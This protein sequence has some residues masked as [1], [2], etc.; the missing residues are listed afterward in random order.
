MFEIADKTV[1]FCT[2]QKAYSKLVY[3]FQ[4]TAHYKEWHKDHISCY[5]KRG[6]DF[7]INSILYAK[8]FLDKIPFILGFKIIKND[9]NK[10]ILFKMLFPFS[11]ICRGGY[12]TF[13]SNDITTE[14]AAQL[15]F[16]GGNIIR[17]IF[18][19][20]VETI[21]THMREEGLSIKRIVEELE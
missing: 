16:R 2:P 15:E 19:K 1:I 6:I 7:S 3:F 20:E 12:F 8:E 17:K 21:R 4:S 9:L 10:E 18:K 11:M 14:M 13:S 5:W